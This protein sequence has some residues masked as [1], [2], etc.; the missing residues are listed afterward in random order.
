MYTEILKKVEELA[1]ARES[2]LVSAANIRLAPIFWET[3]VFL[4]LI[5]LV[6]AS[7]SEITF[8]PGAT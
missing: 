7:F 6:L 2:R 3:I 4:F 5:L 8:P 1:S